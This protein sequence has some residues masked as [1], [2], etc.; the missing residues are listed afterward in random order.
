MTGQAETTASRSS[1]LKQSTHAV[2]DVLDKSIMAADI[3]A[4]RAQF[5][6]FVRMQY[7]FHRDIEALY[8]QPQLQ[9]L[10]PGLAQRC[11]MEE[12]AQDLQALGQNLP[13]PAAPR[14]ASQTPLEEAL[15]WL[16]VAE[17]SNLGG[18]VLFKM[19]SA[20]L[21]LSQ[22]DGLSH[23]AAHPDGAMRHW[24]QF[25]EALDAV[26]LTSQQEERLMQAAQ[27]AFATVQ[28]YA[29]E[30]LGASAAASG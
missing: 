2:H 10:L 28:A 24:R 4:S 8:A 27:T 13:A 16:Y 7:R 18:A 3:F 1:R 6:R 23:L 22:E 15:G 26:E 19:A 21:G 5:G 12:I 14:F 20:K 9:A 11:R 30:E 29:R 17:G 25:T